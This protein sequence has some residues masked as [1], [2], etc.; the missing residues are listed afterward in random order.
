VDEEKVSS[1]SDLTMH[2]NPL[3]NMLTVL[4]DENNVHTPVIV[5]AV[6]VLFDIVSSAELKFRQC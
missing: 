3:I 1:L 5:E 4:A 6:K 2:T